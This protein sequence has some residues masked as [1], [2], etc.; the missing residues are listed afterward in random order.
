ML[1]LKVSS[2]WKT[3]MNSDAHAAENALR[4]FRIM[5][6]MQYRVVQGHA[7]LESFEKQSLKMRFPAFWGMGKL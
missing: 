1:L 6:G 5:V 2:A 3:M 7:P 4:V